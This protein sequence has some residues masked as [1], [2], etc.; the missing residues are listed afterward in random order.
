MYRKDLLKEWLN[1]HLASC[2]WYLDCPIDNTFKSE[3]GLREKF[4]DTY[5]DNPTLANFSFKARGARMPRG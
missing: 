3:R 1:G 4:E 5:C 2:R